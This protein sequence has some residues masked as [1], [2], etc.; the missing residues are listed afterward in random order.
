MSNYI[1]GLDLGSQN[2]KVA[3]AEI[4][5][6][7]KPSL[8]KVFK[9]P[10]SGIRRGIVDDV[11]EATRSVNNALAEVKKI[12]KNAI[13][14]I[15]LGVGSND[16]KIQTSKGIVAVSRADFEISKDDLDRVIDASRALNLPP[17]RMVLHLIIQEFIVDGVGGI[18]DPIGMVG[19]RLEVNSTI[20]DA[21]APTVKNVSRCVE[22]AG[23]AV[24]GLIFGQLAAAR[25]ILSRN[26][27][28][29]GVVLIDIG[30]GKTSMSVYEENR[31]L[32][33]AVFPFGSSHLTNDLAI[34]MKCSVPIAEMVKVSFGSARTGDVP[35][36]EMIDLRRVDPAARGAVTRRSIAEIIEA[37]LGEIF[38]SVDSEL[39]RI[40]RSAK[41]PGGAVIVGGGAKM[42]SI[43]ELAR[44]ELRLPAQIAIPNVEEFNLGGNDLTAQVEDPEYACVIGLLGLGIDKT[45]E[46]SPTSSSIGSRGVSGLLKNIFKSFLP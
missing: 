27:K 6:E 33:A 22:I 39:K 10:S 13:K 15:Y 26:Q 32:H 30:Y 43:V 21:F 14:N 34:G 8:V 9:V 35:A 19:N 45:T 46:G 12:S 25:S 29:L 38:E 44:H 1:V 17:N 3:V 7:G 37:R 5:K 4:K 2:I 18:K 28:E 23:G 42:P 20:V 24:S 41:L 16:T 40:G 36:R 31:L 11:A